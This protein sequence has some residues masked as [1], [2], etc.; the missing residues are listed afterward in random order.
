MS[1]AIE[2][3]ARSEYLP[4]QSQPEKNKFTFAYHMTIHNRGEKPATLISRHWIITDGNGSKNEVKGIGVIGEQPIIA[5]GESYHYSSFS[6]L[7]TNVG[8]ME[9]SYRMR[10]EDDSFFN[11]SIPPFLLAVPG[12]VN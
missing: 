2:V 3:S 7:D 9:G 1:N 10:A 12:A 4:A 8:T 6:V 11:A 5:P